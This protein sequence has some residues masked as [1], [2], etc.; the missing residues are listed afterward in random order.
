MAR[1]SSLFRA[2]SRVPGAPGTKEE[3]HRVA[4]ATVACWLVCALACSATAAACSG[5]RA[6]YANA[7]CHGGG[8]PSRSAVGGLGGSGGTPSTDAGVSV[9][10]G[11]ASGFSSCT[12]DPVAHVTLCLRAAACP[13]VQIDPV[14]FPS[15]G[16]ELGVETLSLECICSGVMLCPIGVGVSCSSLTSL[17]ARHTIAD[18]CNQ[19]VTSSC[20]DLTGAAGAGATAVPSQCDRACAS[21]CAN[22]PLCIAACGC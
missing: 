18:I 22:T 15:C 17:I 10:S 2:S 20:K 19:V 3:A 9:D 11:T 13:T 6:P 7:D 21:E 4:V 5:S 12:T 16:F 1:R 14:A 8:C